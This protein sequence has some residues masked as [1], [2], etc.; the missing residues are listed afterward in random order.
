ME[1]NTSNADSRQNNHDSLDQYMETLAECQTSKV[2]NS[3]I[4]YNDNENEEN[5]EEFY[6]ILSRK[7]Q[8]SEKWSNN[9]SEKKDPAPNQHKTVAPTLKST[10]ISTREHIKDIYIVDEEVSK[11]SL[12][13]CVVYKK[14]L[15]IET[16]GTRVPKPI[17]SFLHLSS[18]VPKAILNRI[19]KMGYFEPTPVQCQAI[20]CILQGRN[21]IILSETGSGKTVSYLIPVVAQILSLIKQWKAVASKKCVYAIILTLTRELCYQVYTLV[22]KICKNINLRIV[23]VSSGVDK[24]EQFRSVLSGC[25]LAICTPARLIDLMTLK[26]VSMGECKYFVVDESDKMF[27]SEYE[28]QTQSIINQLG[29]GT[30]MVFVSASSTEEIQ[31][32]IK[33]LV[34]NAITVKVGVTQIINLEKIELK[35]M[36]MFSNNVT[37]QKKTWLADNIG[38]LESE[39]QTIIF[40]NTR[41][42]VEEVYIFLSSTD[43]TCCMIYGDML[44]TERHNTLSY[45]KKGYFKTLIATDLV[46]RGL[47]IASVG[48]V[49]NYDAPKHFHTFL[50]RVG[51]CGRA[52]ASGVS[53]TLFTKQDSK[54][55]AY[56]ANHLEA[57]RKNT[58]LKVNIPE[59]LKKFALTY[60]PYKQAR[61][62]GVDFVEYMSRGSFMGHQER[63]SR[64]KRPL[65]EE[66]TSGSSSSKFVTSK[67]HKIGSSESLSTASNEE[68]S[69]QG[70]EYSA[71][72]EISSTSEGE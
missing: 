15:N 1:D 30:Q 60:G 59:H 71:T 69:Q 17:S 55:G 31:K 51:R 70:K 53:Y 38:Q 20:P 2:D 9:E 29:E 68:K 42:T 61:R 45:F 27:T 10:E 13:E 4:Y 46:C 21:T 14:K 62:M 63:N 36:M 26:G 66:G 44:P 35:Y 8:K 32:K 49:I 28:D 67:H 43:K 23:M 24:T 72:D 64:G 52:N 54:L 56:I 18:S 48:C 65:E 22:L 12:E 34:R 40:C 19:E 39:S 50:H 7:K 37:V 3:E 57:A 33:S 41:Q 6:A 25:E 5:L 47:D 11:M 58:K 16:F